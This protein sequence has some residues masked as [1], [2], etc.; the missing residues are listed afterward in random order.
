[1][2]E[3]KMKHKSILVITLMV[4][5]IFVSWSAMTPVLVEHGLLSREWQ[6][7]VSAVDAP[8]TDDENGLVDI[9][10][11]NH[12][13]EP[14]L[15][16]DANLTSTNST[17]YGSLNT[18]NGSAGN[19]IPHTVRFD[20]VIKCRFNTTLAY[21]GTGNV[22][23]WADDWPKDGATS[24][25]L[26]VSCNITCG[27]LTITAQNMSGMEITNCSSYIWINFY[28]NN[29]GVGYQITHGMPVNVT[30]VDIRAFY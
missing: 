15:I 6:T 25:R 7:I 27:D 20:I 1:M 30:N 22:W 9:L 23:Q 29:S 8:L 17:T 3:V 16:Y 4:A 21:N 11:V 12:T 13:D 26:W 24:E 14:H 28:V 5:A 18:V 2:E 10:I 19:Y